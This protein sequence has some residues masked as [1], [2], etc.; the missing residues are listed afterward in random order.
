MKRVTAL[1]LTVA[2][3]L[4]LSAVPAV[5]QQE[6]QNGANGIFL[7]Q[8]VNADFTDGSAVTTAQNIPALQFN[9]PSVAATT[10][11]LSC[12]IGYSQATNVADTF[13]IQFSAA[14]AAELI[15]GVAA[16][17]A[18]AYG[19]GTPNST[20]DTSTH[21]VVA[22][23]P[24]VTTVLYAHVGGS[25]ELAA[26]TP[27]TLN[28]QVSQATAANVIVIKRDSVCSVWSTPSK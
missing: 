3:L 20:A 7:Q 14:P 13:A 11:Q 9:I 1:S 24:A 18:T 5:A 17:N 19:S 27:T 23:T 21:T 22:F 15:G 12:E 16:T 6:G 25:F 10:F 8:K 26:N 28:I 4:A 2:A